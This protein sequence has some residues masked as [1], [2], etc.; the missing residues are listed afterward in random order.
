VG[1][2][3]ACALSLAKNSVADEA[4]TVAPRDFG[5]DIPA[6]P[7]TP[8][9]EQRVVTVD[10]SGE[11]VVAQLYCQVGAHHIVMLPDGKLVAR[12]P[13]ESMITDRPWAAI[14]KAALAKG[15]LVGSLA[16]FKTRES[17]RYLY[18]YNTSDEFV[19]VTSRILEQML[20]GISDYY[21]TRRLAVKTPDV[22][23][24][25]VMFR[26]EE[27]FQN[28]RRMPPGVV[29]YYHILTNQVVMYEE[30]KLF[31]VKPELGIQQSIST[32]AH[33]GAHQ[34]LNNIGVQQRLSL[35]PMWLGEGLAE[36][37]APTTVGKRLNWKGVGQV[38]DLRMYELEVY[39]QARAGEVPTG[40]LVTHTVSAA[41]LTSTGYAAAWALTTFLAKQERASFNKYVAEVSKL[42]PFEVQRKTIGR[43]I[44]PQNLVEFQ[45]YFGADTDDLEAR[46]VAYLKRLPYE[47]PFAQWPHFTTFV[48]ATVDG[49]QRRD[50]HVFHTTDLAE[51]WERDTLDKLSPEARDKAQSIVR[52]YPNRQV[53]ERAAAEFLRGK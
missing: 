24:V 27:E 18:V 15:L 53:A 7:V 44:V 51:K 47:D 4:K 49:K 45:E 28:Y 50:A 29:A 11:S 5:F 14:D 32:I 41:R 23:L 10:D 2:G 17:R 16:R 42:G 31:K 20:P 46:L 30:S 39:L 33:E 19:L 38:N 22:P 40:A 34:I 36:Y 52:E 6:G 8:G 37:F 21:Q 9:G 35:W 1:A 12:G 25:V 43:G 48:Q 3:T 13:N 26:T